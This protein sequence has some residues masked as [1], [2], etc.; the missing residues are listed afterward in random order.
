MEVVCSHTH[1]QNAHSRHT[2]Q[3]PRRWRLRPDADTSSS[4]S[5]ISVSCAQS[6]RLAGN[7]THDDVDEH[8]RRSSTSRRRVHI[9]ARQSQYVEV[10]ICCAKNILAR[11]QQTDQTPAATGRHSNI[12]KYYTAL[13]AGRA[14]V[15]LTMQNKQ[16]PAHSSTSTPARRLCTMMLYLCIGAEGGADYNAG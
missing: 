8:P 6:Q 9:R 14:A 16:P 13:R 4:R 15:C 2:H 7:T 12:Y 5:F 10:G 11:R 1:T 3:T